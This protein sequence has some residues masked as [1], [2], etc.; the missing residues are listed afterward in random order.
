MARKFND[1]GIEL[2]LKKTLLITP[3]VLPPS[4]SMDEENGLPTL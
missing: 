4:C 2:L 3:R 1:D